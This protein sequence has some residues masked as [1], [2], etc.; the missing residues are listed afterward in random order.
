MGHK[1]INKILTKENS[2]HEREKVTHIWTS[3]ETMTGVCASQGNSKINID[4]MFNGV[5]TIHS[6]IFGITSHKAQ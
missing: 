4:S 2:E 3:Q 1:Q 5:T 6:V